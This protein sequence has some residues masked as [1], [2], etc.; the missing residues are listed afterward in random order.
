MFRFEELKAMAESVGASMKYS[1]FITEKKLASNQEYGDFLS[2][3]EFHGNGSDDLAFGIGLSNLCR[4]FNW[5]GGTIHQAKTALKWYLMTLG[6]FEGKD[7]TIG[8][9]TFGR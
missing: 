9:F 7:G 2:L 5:Q 1:K 6:I 4:F 8:T 3:V